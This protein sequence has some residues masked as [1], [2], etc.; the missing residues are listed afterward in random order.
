MSGIN[1]IEKLLMKKSRTNSPNYEVRNMK[2][3]KCRTFE[4]IVEVLLTG[5]KEQ[6]CRECYKRIV[7][8]RLESQGINPVLH[9]CNKCGSFPNE[10]I[11][12]RLGYD[13]DYNLGIYCQHCMA[14]QCYCKV[15]VK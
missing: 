9:K 2:C 6:L 4:A 12:L 15:L 1:F 5:N 7:E 13:E 10:I 8:K 14:K 11:K 3:K